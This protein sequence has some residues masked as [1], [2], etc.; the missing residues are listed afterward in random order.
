MK[1]LD[2]EEYETGSNCC[3]ANPSYLNESL[4][5]ECLES[6][7]LLKKLTKANGYI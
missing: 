4:C 7:S 5:G 2:E 6:E 1:E 3:G